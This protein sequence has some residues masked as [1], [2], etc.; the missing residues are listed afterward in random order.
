MRVDIRHT[1]YIYKS[2]AFN[3]YGQNFSGEILLMAIS[4]MFAYNWYYS[5]LC[6]L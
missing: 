3:M 5:I 1:E 2:S 4:Y 6:I